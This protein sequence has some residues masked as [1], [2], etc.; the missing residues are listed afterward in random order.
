MIRTMKIKKSDLCTFFMKDQRKTER[1]LL[2]VQ[3]YYSL[4][5]QDAWNGPVDL[6]NI[7]GNGLRCTVDK[8]FPLNT[9]LD[10]RIFLPTESSA[11]I[12]A[13]GKVVWIQKLSSQSN[14]IGI[15]LIKMPPDDRRAY[16]EFLSDKILIKHLDKVSI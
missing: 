4:P 5:K 10:I 14:L 2:P 7:S 13:K 6:E 15:N 8:K 3:I 11:P 16:I 12:N 9:E 1:L